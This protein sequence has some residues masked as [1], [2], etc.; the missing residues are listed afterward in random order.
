VQMQNYDPFG[1]TETCWDD[2]SSES[3]LVGIRGQANA[4]NAGVK[5]LYRSHDQEKE[6]NEAF[7]IQPQEAP[8]QCADQRHLGLNGL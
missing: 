1:S 8:Q 3:L 4:G 7:L 5:I 2:E 6:E